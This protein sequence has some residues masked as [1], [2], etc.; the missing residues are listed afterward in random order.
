MAL[1]A[2]QELKTKHRAMWTSGNYPEMVETFL[3]PLGPPLV[4]AAGITEDDRVLDVAS[5]TGNAA[6]PRRN[7]APLSWR[8]T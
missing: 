5:G 1:S 8:V 6:I 4:E 3:L 7:V 2:D